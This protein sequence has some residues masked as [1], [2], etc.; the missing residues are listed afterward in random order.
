MAV[1]RL[2][3]RVRDAARAIL[4]NGLGVDVAAVDSVAP[5]FAVSAR[6]GAVTHR[7]VVGWA[8][9]GW[10]ADVERLLRVAADVDAVAASALSVGAREML[11]ERKVGWFDE[12]GAAHLELD[13]GLVVVR[14]GARQ[15][16][17]SVRHEPR[18]T[19]STIAVA[20]AILCGVEP[21]VDDIQQA[22]RL[23]RGAAAN[24]LT[25]L[26]REELLDRAVARGP[27]SARRV[28]DVGMLLDRYTAAVA[29]T[30]GKGP[31]VLLHR[32][33]DDPLDS[34]IHEIAPA[35][36]KANVPWAVTGAAG[37]LLIAPYLSNVTVV[38]LYTDDSLVGNSRQLA[39]LL[40]ARQVDRGHRIEIRALPNQI[41]A[42]AGTVIDGV[43]CAPAVRVYADL[44]VK[45]GRSAE[46]AQ[47]L[48]E[49]RIDARASA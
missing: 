7:F 6:S 32:L 29:D 2:T 37:S 25:L 27:G 19:G 26:E 23:S 30:A 12:T 43:R 14:D 10:P 34:L 46:A 4:P 38:E 47:H 1:R 5:T 42:T 17:P 35:F 36:E 21:R 18:W 33:W 44:S 28:I 49:V 39:E 24:A 16:S 48:R 11:D 8:G 9:E 22:T 20:E 40:G 15:A 3:T 13:G 31:V 45:G 41:T